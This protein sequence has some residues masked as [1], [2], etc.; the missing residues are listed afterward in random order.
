MLYS[1]IIAVCSQIHTKQIHCVGRTWN[2]CFF[3]LAV[4][5]VTTRV[6]RVKGQAMKRCWRLEWNVHAL[7]PLDR[8]WATL[9]PL[10]RSSFRLSLHSLPAVLQNRPCSGEEQKLLWRE[11]DLFRPYQQVIVSNYK[12]FAFLNRRCRGYVVVELW[13]Y[14]SKN[15]SVNC[16]LIMTTVR[17]EIFALLGCYPA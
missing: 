14:V 6:E 4:R 2:C 7:L 8:E 12:W 16:I 1:E 15:N 17:V 3:N 11:S 13:L 10:C 5:I 9:R